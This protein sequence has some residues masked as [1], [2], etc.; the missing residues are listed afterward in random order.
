MHKKI[1]TFRNCYAIIYKGVI[2]DLR[3]FPFFFTKGGGIMKKIIIVLIL[4][5]ILVVISSSETV[6]ITI[7]F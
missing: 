7:N 2:I 6:N 4:V 5:I 1:Y 3:L